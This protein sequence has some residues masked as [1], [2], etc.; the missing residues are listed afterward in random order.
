MQEKLM[1]Q[2]ELAKRWSVAEATLERWRTISPIT[3]T[4]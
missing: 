1:T 3:V 2:K 4:P